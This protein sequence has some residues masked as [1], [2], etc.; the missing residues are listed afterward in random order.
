[1]K[2]NIKYGLMA[3]GCKVPQGYFLNGFFYERASN[4]G[5]AQGFVDEK[6][7]FYS[8]SNG[9]HLKSG[10]PTAKI[11]GLTYIRLADVA[12]FDLVMFDA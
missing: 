2:R 10:R 5:S 3:K 8:S 7:F 1:M 4:H 9:H 12:E 6:G 11:E